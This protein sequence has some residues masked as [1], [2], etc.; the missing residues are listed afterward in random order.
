MRILRW[1]CGSNSSGGT[2]ENHEIP[3][4]LTFTFTQPSFVSI[5]M[6]FPVPC[7]IPSSRMTTPFSLFHPPPRHVCYI[8]CDSRSGRSPISPCHPSL[9]RSLLTAC[10]RVSPFLLSV[11]IPF[12]SFP[13]TLATLF[14]YHP[15]LSTYV[16][17]SSRSAIYFSVAGFSFCFNERPVLMCTSSPFFH[18]GAHP[19][20]QR[21]F[22][23]TGSDDL[24]CTWK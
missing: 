20:G 21:A 24:I 3:R 6:Y 22:P 12:S 7:C 2:F 10:Y 8:A 13:G 4:I 16:T 14:L 17:L 19:L 18:Y 15:S 11:F 9:E 23:V 5:W 1:R